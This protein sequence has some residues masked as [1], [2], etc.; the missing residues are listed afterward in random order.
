MGICPK[1]GTTYVFIFQHPVTIYVGDMLKNDYVKRPTSQE[2]ILRGILADA[3]VQKALHFGC[4][5]L[6]KLTAAGFEVNSY[7]H[8]TFFS[9]YLRFSDLKSYGLDQVAERRFP[10]FA[11]YHT[12][13]ADE[14][15]RGWPEDAP[16]KHSRPMPYL[17]TVPE[18]IRNAT[19]C[20]E[21]QVCS[22]SRPVR[23]YSSFRCGLSLST[24]ART[25][26]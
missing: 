11:G 2:T 1:P 18:N 24:M 4:T 8:D 16:F 3:S 25:A 20:C 7:T 23:H 5:D 17:E 26:M 12:I 15:L 14:M 9:E 19:D 13:V 10:Q 21:I 6:V 22:G